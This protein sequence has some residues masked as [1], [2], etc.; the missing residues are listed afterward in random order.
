MFTRQTF[1]ILISPLANEVEYEGIPN[2]QYFYRLE[3]DNTT[4][5][6]EIN[7]D[8]KQSTVTQPGFIPSHL[9]I[10]TWVNFNGTQQIP[11]SSFIMRTEYTC[12][13]SF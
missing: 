3:T 5:F 1:G 13:I 12:T 7:Q 8:I 4:L 2:G 6:N 10:A 11:V 9:V